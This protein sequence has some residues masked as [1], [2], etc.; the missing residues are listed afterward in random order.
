[1]K[2]VARSCFKSD[3]NSQHTKGKNTRQ[4]GLQSMGN[5]QLSN[6]VSCE[7]KTDTEPPGHE[8]FM[9]NRKDI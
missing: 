5:L 4:G 3:D 7:K 1:M 9:G 2:Q 6:E 8:S